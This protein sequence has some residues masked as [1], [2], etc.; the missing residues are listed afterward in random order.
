MFP[1]ATLPFY[2]AESV[3]VNENDAQVLR[4]RMRKP[5]RHRL[6]HGYPLAAA[7]RRRNPGQLPEDVFF[8]PHAGRDLLVG[9]LPHPF[10]NPAVTGCGFCTF[11]HE[12]YHA[13][14]AGEVVEHVVQEIDD[15]LARQPALARRRVAAL[16]IGGGTAN[17]TPAGPF[18][19]LCRRLTA[20]FDL[21]DAE[22]TLEGVPAYF[23]LRKPLLIDIL[24]VEMDARHFRLSMGVQTFDEG[25]LRQMGRLA[26]GSADTFAEVVEMAHARG[27]T[28]SADLLFNLPGQGLGEMCQDVEHAVR[29]G[30][31]H[32]GLYHLVLFRGL[33]TAWSRDPAMLAG[34]PTN[35]QA[36]EHWSALR[37]LLVERGFVQTTLTN[38]EQARYRG[39]DR[40]FLY[41]ELSFQ[42]DRHDMAGFGPGAISFAAGRSFTG[43][44]KQLNP[45]GAD[46]YMAGVRSGQSPWD[47][48]FEYNATDLR[49]FYLTR[50]LA[51]LEIDR[52][53]YARL[54][55]TDPLA[56]FA[57]A[58]GALL[59]EGL[60]E[61]TATTVRPTARG[62][63]Y[64]D[65]IA[66]L[67]AWRQIEA[68]RQ[69]MLPRFPVAT[70]A[71][72]EAR[73]P[74]V[75]DNGRGYM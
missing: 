44:L 52:R 50:R 43:G 68:R 55:G 31:D 11:P 34:L 39:D 13:G 60:L 75:N 22:V 69:G 14:R 21:S 51:A 56:D 40:R 20:A 25:R 5:Q 66:S 71:D 72:A 36:A 65:S 57:G 42:P 61:I 74:S 24:R 70:P 26:F 19:L 12:R 62:M 67:L 30:L 64:A 15:R 63:F 35:E 54:F 49:I 10:C 8:D 4:D 28:V 47:R 3:P 41:E 7:M 27:F 29:I 48:Y 59:D 18:R 53:R 16:Y 46:S 58:F 9:V 45:D 23:V 17:L 33:G 1:L 73:W 6:L 37:E 32:L 38:F 2:R